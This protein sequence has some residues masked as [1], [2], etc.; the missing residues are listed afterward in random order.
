MSK[1]YFA[2][3]GSYGWAGNDPLLFDTEGWTL[4]DWEEIENCLDSERA[5]VARGVASKYAS[6]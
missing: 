6:H 3:D 2:E 4:A 5:F 1:Y